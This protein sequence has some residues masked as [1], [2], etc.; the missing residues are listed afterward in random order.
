MNF[1][2]F[3]N[4]QQEALQKIF[5]LEINALT[6][7][8]VQ[9]RQFPDSYKEL[10]LLK[11]DSSFNSFGDISFVFSKQNIFGQHNTIPK[12]DATHQIYAG[13]AYTLRFPDISFSVDI[14]NKNNFIKEI[15]NVY[16]FDNV[17]EYIHDNFEL[18]LERK[19]KDKYRIKENLL[20]SLSIKFLFL[21][22]A[23][24]LDKF[25]VIE[26]KDTQL[27]KY[28]ENDSELKTLLKETN[29]L[30]I[31][32]NKQEYIDFITKKYNSIKDKEEKEVWKLLCYDKDNNPDPIAFFK[33]F[34]KDINI[35]KNKNNSKINKEKTNELLN[36]L[37]KKSEKILNTKFEDFLEYHLQTIFHSPK[38]KENNKP[39]T[40]DNIVS[41][42]KRQ[43]GNG[44]EQGNFYNYNRAAA[45]NQNTIR[46]YEDME[47][48]SSNLINS[49]GLA[50]YDQLIQNKISKIGQKVN[51]YDEEFID[52]IAKL[53]K[54]PS[55]DS[56]KKQ[57]QNM[58]INI[59]D[60]MLMLDI[61]ELCKLNNNR[62]HL[63]FEAKPNKAFYFDNRTHSDSILTHVVVPNDINQN[64]LKRLEKTNL[65]IIKYNPKSENSLSRLK[66]LYQCRELFIN[67]ENKRKIIKKNKP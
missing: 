33:V 63:Y 42:M 43:R 6:C 10:D 21:K 59:E 31:R 22:E 30:T 9:I 27:T 37:L 58:E 45:M 64:L 55:L 32:N 25:K 34:Q 60:P 52:K 18:E 19:H 14:K 5:D 24:I 54:N 46:S 49:E 20:N 61:Q 66:A 50:K 7:P 3:S 28:T 1:I 17:K 4:I 16:N 8:S 11:D 56:I 67:N 57:F 53:G 44:V 29:T 65:K 62:K 47:A 40:A 15:N 36:K 39:L 51:A 12:N 38:I 41:Y 35:L 23:G 48:N 13:D 2:A 26:D